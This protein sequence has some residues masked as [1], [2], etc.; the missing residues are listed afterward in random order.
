MHWKAFWGKRVSFGGIYL[1]FQLH[2]SFCVGFSTAK[3]SIGHE[4][5]RDSIH[6]MYRGP[7][8]TYS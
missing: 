3:Y 6:T 4:V 5:I 7:C 2:V 1:G 8:L